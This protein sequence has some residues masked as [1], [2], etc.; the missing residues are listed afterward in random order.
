MEV[1]RRHTRKGGGKRGGGWK[2]ESCGVCYAPEREGIGT[3]HRP[4]RVTTN[5]HCSDGSGITM[6]TLR[7]PYTFYMLENDSTGIM[8]Q[9]LAVLCVPGVTGNV[10]E[11][12]LGTR[13]GPH[14]SYP[15]PIQRE[16]LPA[17]FQNSP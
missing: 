11:Q 10:D 5:P 3:R 17:S 6:F 4:S 15:S 9:L 7:K 16:S 1:Q 2:E 12:V 13:C 14:S 8:R